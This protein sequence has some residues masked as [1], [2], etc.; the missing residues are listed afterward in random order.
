MSKENK[1]FITVTHG[2]SGYFAV[3]L[4]WE[5]FDDDHDGCYTPEQTGIGRYADKDKAEIEAKEWAE[6]EEIPYVP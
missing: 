4:T 2:C 5:V 3:L 1:P 6:C